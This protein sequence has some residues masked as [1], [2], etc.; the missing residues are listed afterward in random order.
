MTVWSS[1]TDELRRQAGVSRSSQTTPSAPLARETD[2]GA[3]RDDLNSVVLRNTPAETTRQV[4]FSLVESCM[5][6]SYAPALDTRSVVPVVILRN[7]LQ[8]VHT[9]AKL[10][11]P[12][13]TRRP[14]PSD[15]EVIGANGTRSTSRGVDSEAESQT[16]IATHCPGL[17]AER[18]N[19][20][21]H[22][23]WLSIFLLVSH[24]V[25]TNSVG[26]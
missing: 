2:L 3:M 23:Q 22:E 8:I 21:G 1:W 16:R 24:L 9:P 5:R 13:F 17:Q 14:S 15:M 4:P 20:K 19:M 7:V 6:H 11:S 26:Q 10:R 25:D 12:G 18:K